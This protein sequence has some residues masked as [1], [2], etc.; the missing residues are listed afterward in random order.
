M[1]PSAVFRTSAYFF[2]STVLM[3]M[4]LRVDLFATQKVIT[5]PELIQTEEGDTDKGETRALPD[6]FLENK[7]YDVGEVYE[8]TPV[9]HS[10]V[11]KNRGKG[12]LLIQSVKPG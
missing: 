2:I 8:D 12:D 5:P 9:T 11:I 4:L 10:F 7:E 1:N 6:M 3:V